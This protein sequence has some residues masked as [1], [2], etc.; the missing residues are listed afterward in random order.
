MSLSTP[1]KIAVPFANG[2]SKN[3]IPVLSQTGIIPNGASYTD[4]F[5]ALT[6]TI[7]SAGGLPP[8]GQ[9]M[10]G[11]LYDITN[12]LRYTQAGGLYPYDST[13]AGTIGGYSQGAMVQASDG[14]GAWLNTVAN[15]T[16]NPESFG[17][18]WL[19]FN[20]VGGSAIALSN[21]NVTLTALQAGKLII[22][23]TGVISSN[24]NLVF[25]TWINEWTIIN[26]T[27]GG[28]T[29]TAKTALGSGVSM[30]YGENKVY[31][32]GQN[33]KSLLGT[34]LLSSSGYQKFLGGM[35]IQWGN[36][37]GAVPASGYNQYP[38]SFP[39]TFPNSVFSVVPTM[40]FN[41]VSS[42]SANTSVYMKTGTTTSGG[43]IIVDTT[44]ADTGA[45]YLTYIAIGY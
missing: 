2:G 36:L 13:F 8:R 28:F 19:P 27:T 6:M 42:A 10:N 37:T 26:N 38:F 11:I 34:N 25:P 35:I 4:G 32:D 1:S 41:P 14:T 3:S 9:D 44:G 5:P 24:I 17:V 23:L 29:V 40:S 43:T 12:T 31:G 33:I 18:G 30:I 16:S 20:Q 7:K 22:I 21:A 39:V 15:N 45:A